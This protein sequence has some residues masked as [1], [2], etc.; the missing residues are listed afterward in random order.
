VSRETPL[1]AAA[2]QRG[3]RF[4]DE[5]GWLLPS[6]FSDVAGELTALRERAGM[7]DVSNWGHFK[8]TGENSVRFLQG[9][10][11][12][13][14]ARLVPGVGCYSAFLN[15]HG[16]IE[17]DC[18]IFAFDGELLLQTSPEATAWVARSLGRFNLAGGFTLESLEVTHAAV[19]LCGPGAPEA[20]ATALGAR[21]DD[22]DTF[23]CRSL[24]TPAGEVRLLGVRRAPMW[25]VDVLAP[26]DTVV[27]LSGALLG[28]MPRGVELVGLDAL[29]VLRLEA[30]VPRFGRDFGP[31]SVLQ[32]ID[33][34]EIVS[35]NKGCYLGQ[36]I[37][38]RIHF[39][40]QPSKLLR[41]LE[42]EGDA[43]PSPG[44]PL[45]AGEGEADRE[46]G[47]VTS[48][49]SSPAAGF[50]VFA[51]VKRKHYAPGTAVRVRTGSGLVRATVVER[52]PHAAAK[53]AR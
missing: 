46:V 22:L 25:G 18:H 51:I 45:V 16:R 11:T 15:V 8:L 9:L 47:V 53:E 48:A 49:V 13:D 37:V 30:G 35:F 21:V 17:A 33:V 1:H 20:L 27:D 39:Q 28:Q 41:R 36:E 4:R 42:V 43:L 19:T 50:I 2:A 32:E 24:A 31:D 3:A 14:V 34:P 7:A 40:G 12:N 29:E 38:A 23:A 44:D 5:G 6:T 52:N 10:T 26:R